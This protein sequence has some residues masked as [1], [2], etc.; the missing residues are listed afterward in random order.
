MSLDAYFS[1]PAHLEEKQTLPL[2]CFLIERYHQEKP[3]DGLTVV[4]GHILVRNSMAAAEALWAGGAEVVLCDAFPS[5]A[6]ETVLSDLARHQVPVLTVEQAVKA[7]HIFVD[8]DA[9]L[10]RQ[11]T[12]RFAAEVTR[13][14]V[15]HYSNIPSPVISADD[16][17]AKRIEGFFGIGDGFIRAWKHLRPE[18]PL[19][20]KKVVQFGYGKIGRGLAHRT[21]SA[22][23][24][25]V[26]ADIDPYNRARADEDGFQSLDGHP[27]T[28]L[29]AKLTEA[30]VVIAVTGIPGILSRALPPEWLR[31]NRPVLVNMGAEDEFG[32]AFEDAEI[33]G[34]KALP[35]NFHLTQPTL[36]RYIDP[37]LAAHVLALEALVRDPQAYPIGVHP[38]PEEM[39]TWLLKSWRAAWPHENLTGIGDELGLE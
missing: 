34:G 23:M 38:L 32:D 25:V 11:R 33:L 37:S 21:H 27:N 16:S 5:P 10:G 35:I 36:N 3:F 22:G 18:D 9:I 8:T 31:A 28:G 17:L 14:G 6:T 4:L 7:G 19:E 24:Q 30:E 13:T 15:L 2:L 26:V 39:D 1:E 29:I 20:G 12:P